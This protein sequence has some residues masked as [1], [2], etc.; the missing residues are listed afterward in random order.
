MKKKKKKKR[1]IKL[2]THDGEQIKQTIRRTPEIDCNKGGNLRGHEGNR[3]KLS[4]RLGFIEAKDE[5]N[6]QDKGDIESPLGGRVQGEDC[7]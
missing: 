4:H 1:K 7:L 5:E 2:L 3:K 6:S